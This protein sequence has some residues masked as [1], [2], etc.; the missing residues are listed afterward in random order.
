MPGRWPHGQRE[1]G[2]AGA[3]VR[4]QEWTGGPG[5]DRPGRRDAVD[6]AL[7]AI[8]DEEVAP[9]VEGE[10]IED[11]V[12]ARELR[13]E[14]WRRAVAADAPDAVGRWVPGRQRGIHVAGRVDGQPQQDAAGYG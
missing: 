12:G 4:L 6:H 3:L 2:R 11:G 10:P 1:G 14:L 5:T 9:R 13:E 8:G 7:A